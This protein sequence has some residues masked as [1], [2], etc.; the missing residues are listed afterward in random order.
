MSSSD[1][2][3]LEQIENSALLIGAP[4]NST[5]ENPGDGSVITSLSPAHAKLLELHGS[6]PHSQD[7]HGNQLDPSD[8]QQH[9][10]T[11]L[12]QATA[13]YMNK[14]G[15]FFRDQF[16][17]SGQLAD[18]D[19][20]LAAYYQAVELTPDGDADKA[21]YLMKLG[22]SYSSRFDRLGSPFDNYKGIAA[23]QEALNL[24]P[25]D[26]P[27]KAR[28]LNNLGNSFSSRLRGLL[29]PNG[30]ANVLGELVDIEN[31]IAAQQEA[32]DLTPNGH[33]DK[34]G[35]LNNLGGSF[36]YCFDQLGE[37]A[38]I[39]KAI[40][41]QQK[42]VNLMLDG[43]PHRAGCLS[44]LGNSFCSKFGQFEELVDIENAIAA[45]LGAL[46]NLI[47]IEKA[48]AAQQKAVNITSENHVPKARHLCYLGNALCSRFELVGELVDI[49][50]AITVQQ[51]SV[52]LTPDDH[53][54]KA[55]QLSSLGNSFLSRF[56][57]LGELV[58][59]EKAISMQQE[60]V[61]RIPDGHAGR[62]GFLNNLAVSFLSRFKQLHNLVDNDKA[63]AAQQEAL[64]LTPD[65]HPDKPGYLN[66]LGNSFR[67]S[68][69]QLHELVDIDK[70]IATYQE[71]VNLTPDNHANK[72]GYL[73]N[74]GGAFRQRFAQIA[75][76]GDID[77]AIA[78]EQHAVNLTPDGH[79][80]KA[81]YRC[82][83][84][85][86]F[87]SQY[88]QLGWLDSS[89]RSLDALAWASLCSVNGNTSSALEAYSMLLEI[90]PQHIGSAINAAA[91]LALEWLEE[92]RSIVWGQIL[93]LQTPPN[94]LHIKYPVLAEK[95]HQVTTAL[96]RAGTLDTKL[97][98]QDIDSQRSQLTAEQEA[99]RN[100][101]LAAEYG[102][103]L[104]QIRNL[105]GFN[106]FLQPK[107]LAELVHA[108]NNGPVVIINVHETRC[109]ALILHSYNTLEPIIHV[110]LQEFSN[111]KAE[112]LSS[113]MNSIL[114]TSG[115]RKLVIA[116]AETQSSAE[117]LQ[118]ILGNL[119][120]WVVQPIALKIKDI[121]LNVIG[122]S[123]PHITWCATGPLAFLPL[124]AA[125]TYGPEEKMKIYDYAVSSYSP[126][127][128]TLLR[129]PPRYVEAL[130]KVLIV[131]QSKTPGQIPLY[132]TLMEVEAVLK[133]A[134]AENSLHLNAEHATVTK[135]LEELGQNEWVH[136]AC[137]GIQ[138]TQ[139]PL[140]NA[141]ALYDGNLELQSLMR[142][143]F[144]NAQLAFL[145]AC[146]TATGD[147]KLPE[148]AVHLAAGMLTAGFPSVVGAMWEIRD[149]DV[150]VI[151]GF[152]YLK[153]NLHNF[154]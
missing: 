146:Q 130:P 24:T 137:H 82:Y 113:K 3:D 26:H 83:L 25:D 132:G 91:A 115:S 102:R 128:S 79:T 7:D 14:H 13:S 42:A 109:D 16:E 99:Q 101:T 77:K 125:G 103:L 60:A 5:S 46:G 76:L 12:L 118:S 152:D 29:T 9:M 66:N 92:G 63:I 71:A 28:Y 122:D 139:D 75:D 38:D 10:L 2:I 68:F 57:Y 41:A 95:L 58:D 15:D 104:K 147:E 107:K 131:S 45:Q 96:E 148:E 87:Y 67:Y 1:T 53:A 106:D 89:D 23:Q 69:E 112:M 90:I 141:F 80:L 50:K 43:H 4:P 36:R 126:A 123:M 85:N 72:A 18:T 19:E 111:E 98:L 49:D 114:K 150:P 35:F 144:N 78:A 34:A 51:E 65:D 94:D 136:L 88:K 105:D 54:D 20:A 134:S 47:D 151:A 135:V 27:D 124:H 21:Q 154:P 64:N 81:R 8:E 110:L 86:S 149:K 61:N 40:A 108:A 142:T 116:A 138:N 145:S 37:L 44:N 127:L 100:H 143:S 30:H 70:A 59:I 48:I 74:L 6:L 33:P 84:G 62:A 119:W 56:D 55:A 121:L 97:S 133:Y 17:K 73:N 140:K 120:S 11:D 22:I 52:S 93:Q 129:P 117:I 31:A 39:E 32:V 153:K